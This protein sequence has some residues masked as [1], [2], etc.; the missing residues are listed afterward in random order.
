MIKNKKR[1]KE[2]YITTAIDYVN[3][4]PH[5]GHAFEKV[6]ADAIAR[7]YRLQ[8]REVFFL[9]GTDENAQKNAQAAKEAGMPTKQFVDKNV[10]AF[11]ELC[12]KLNLSNND[13]IRTTET[14]HVKVAQ[15]V[16]EEVYKKGDIYKGTYEGLYCY[17]CEAYKT[18]KDLVNGKCPEHPNRKIAML[19]EEAY[20]FR[21][22]KYKQQIIKFVNN[23]IVPEKRKN[24]IL[25]RLK[26]EE[27]RD[28]CVSR[29]GL[30]W[31]IDVPFDRKHKIYVWIDALSNYISG[32]NGNWPADLHVIGK[33]INWFHSVIWPAIL[34]SAGY[35]LPK[36]LLVHGYLNLSGRKISKSSGVTID[37][38]ELVDKYGADVVRYSLL[39]CS[40]FEDSDYDEDILVERN[41]SEL[42]DK[43]GNLVSRVSALAE[44]YGMEKCENN[45][46]KKLKFKDI[47]TCLK[48]YELDKAL[49]L[50]FEF[51]DSCNLYIQENELWKSHDKKK[52]FELC[53]SIKA[54]AILLWP[55]IP[56]TSEKI[57]KLLGFEIKN[58]EQINK[59]LEIK[60]IKKSE[61]L[62][63][64]IEIEK[65]IEKPEEIKEK[66]AQTKEKME[67]IPFNE[68]AKLD[69]RVGKIVGVKPHPN[70]DKLVLLEIDL[71]KE[72]GKRTLVAGI[73]QYYNEK[74]LKG[75]QIIVFTNLEPKE[76]RGVKSGGMILAAV[77]N[78]KSKVI[79]I[80]PEKEI[81]PGSKV[82]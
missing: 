46:L 66:E 4:R 32:A 44:Q 71:G 50:V 69:L 15:E 14:R 27:L 11:I 73:K 76:V 53:D 79:L 23:H 81:E 42:A 61:I 41:N 40:V 24:E 39:R 70:A 22:S 6:L 56:E 34:I 54:I 59:P 47:K 74:E 2:F 29:Q 80:T 52:L 72:L 3:A 49:A 55:F 51:I 26:E 7:W 37:P 77:N 17:G 43:L 35:D 16:F 28:L 36:K 58:I 62:F 67:T 5:I 45:L 82:E 31:G 48:N 1:G 12:K 9:T 33:G 75:K 8:G 21:L 19:K 64:K 57:T 63:K 78:D 20:F 25:S 30:D 13:F 38:I 60:K 65:K 68:W 18:E 10:K